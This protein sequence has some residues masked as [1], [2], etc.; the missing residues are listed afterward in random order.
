MSEA[1]L[2]ARVVLLMDELGLAW[3]H[4]YEP[5][6]CGGSPG[7]P[8]LTIAGSGGIVFRELKSEDG[9]VTLKQRQLGRRILAAGGNWGVWRPVNLD[10]GSIESVLRHLADAL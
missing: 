7:W 2:L 3:H 5:R 9:R 1:E 10:S 4:C 8:D 6:C